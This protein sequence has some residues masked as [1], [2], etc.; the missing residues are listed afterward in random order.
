MATV[1]LGSIKFNWK[2]NWATSTAYAVDD[3]VFNNPDSYVCITAHTSHASDAS[4]V[5]SDSAYWNKMAAGGTDPAMGGDMTGTASNAQIAANAVGTAEIATNAVGVAELNVTDGTVGQALMTDG[6]GGLSF[7][8]V[9]ADFSTME[10]NLAI[11]AFHS[12][13]T[14]AKYY[15][16]DQVID[17]F[18]D[19][20]GIDTTNSIG[21]GRDLAGYMSGVINVPGN[22]FGDGTLGNCQFLSSGIAQASNTTDIDT[23]LTTGSVSSGPGNNSYGGHN[24]SGTAEVGAPTSQSHTNVPN[25]TA[26]YEFTVPAKNTAYDGDMTVL[27]FKDLTI[28]AGNTVTVDQPCRGML[29]YVD[30][31]CEINGALSMTSRGAHADPSGTASSDSA[32]VHAL[33]LQMPIKKTGETDTLA[34]AVF[35]GTGTPAVTAVAN[36][37]AIGTAPTNYAGKIYTVV[38]IGGAGGPRA[39]TGSNSDVTTPGGTIANGTGGGGGGGS[40]DGGVLNQ[41]GSAGT[42]FS[43]GSAGGGSRGGTSGSAGAYGP[44]DFGG[45]GGYSGSYIPGMGGSTDSGGSGNPGGNASHNTGGNGTGG[46]LILMVSGTLTIGASGKICADGEMAGANGAG[47]ANGEGGGGSSGGGRL[48]IGHVGSFTGAVGKATALGAVTHGDPG[49]YSGF[50]GSGG[51]GAVDF[52]VIDSATTTSAGDM[53]LISN[54]FTA[55]NT[56]TSADL[57]LHIEDMYANTVIGTDLK[58]YVSRNGNSDWSP[59]LTLTTE[60][61]L[62]SNQKILVAKGIDLTGLAGTT[63]M[64]YKL[65]STGQ[66]LASKETRIHAVSLAWNP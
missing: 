48:I 12:A 45:R 43:G 24:V 49:S 55:E 20:T 9:A 38:K 47:D 11:V 54:T 39:A 64:R 27:N 51:D 33:G 63:S 29:V 34:A 56:A 14:A 44:Q 26:C 40:H 37:P 6:S 22:H 59:E 18:G 25:C 23:V 66:V 1:D 7:G 65:V 31:D 58:A 35:A 19:T 3:V 10:T 4:L 61:D 62:G 16:E 17:N 5:T 46:L 13:T 30:G 42:C 50:G 21:E 15:M 8:T 36:N 2:N 52:D 53:T 41:D 60:V 28:D 57:I 32:S